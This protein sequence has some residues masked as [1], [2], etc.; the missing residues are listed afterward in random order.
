[1]TSRPK[2]P[3]VLVLTAMH[4]EAAA[5]RRALRTSG[6]S[7]ISVRAVGIGAKDELGAAAPALVIAAGLAGGLNPTLNT[8]DAVV[9]TTDTRVQAGCERLGIRI[10]RIHTSDETIS[11]AQHK[12][13]LFE[14]T[15]ADCVDMENSRLRAWA[16][17][18]GAAFIGLRVICDTARDALNADLLGAIDAF[19][20]PRPFPLAAVILRK[21]GTIRSMLSLWRQSRIALPRLGELA[22]SVARDWLQ[23]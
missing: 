11:T 9:D 13:Q 22:A 18:H 7:E 20:S 8:G 5:I 21:P 19:G 10:G 2:S 1:M 6:A 17:S 15:C 23:A 14:T 4:N 12:A 16:L 3:R